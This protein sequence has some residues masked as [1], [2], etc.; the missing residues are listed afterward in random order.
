MLGLVMPNFHAKKGADTAAQEGNGK[1][2]GFRDTPFGV[3][4]FPLVYAI[5][6]EGNQV[7]CCEVK[8]EAI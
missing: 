1:E 8:Q 3:A 6:E 4:G 2:T 5:E 7:D